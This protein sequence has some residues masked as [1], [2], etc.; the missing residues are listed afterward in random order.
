MQSCIP[1]SPFDGWEPADRRVLLANH[2]TALA[3]EIRKH[4]QVVAV[5]HLPY[6]ETNFPE[7]CLRRPRDVPCLHIEMGRQDRLFHITALFDDVP[8]LSDHV[9]PAHPATRDRVHSDVHPVV[10]EKHHRRGVGR[11]RRGIRLG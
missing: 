7:Q 6:F 9:T 8:E 4:P 2:E 11:N 10:V 3:V 5:E 1:K